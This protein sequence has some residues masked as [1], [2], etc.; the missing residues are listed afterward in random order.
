MKRWIAVAALALFSL[1]AQAEV[2]KSNPYTM[3]NQVADEAFAR[4][5]AEQE[6]IQAD[7]EHLRGLVKELFLPYVNARYAAY[8]VLGPQLRQ[9]SK[10]DREL[11]VLAFTE[12]M[13]ASYA[14]VLT[15]YEGQ[16]VKVEGDKSI[17]EGRNIITVRVEIIDPKRPAIRIDF[18]MRQNKKTGEWQGFDM[19]AEGVSL[20]TTMQN[21]WGAKIRANGAAAVAEELEVLAA[22]PIA[23]QSAEAQNG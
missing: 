11:F 20:L 5:A 21:E 10:E 17:P 12:Y 3:M 1:F 19:T 9:T 14:Q 2:D 22:K 13:V 16:T 18:A 8:K 15:Q 4:L 6:S 23:K 7:P